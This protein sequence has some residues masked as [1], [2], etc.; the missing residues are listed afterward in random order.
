MAPEIKATVEEEEFDRRTVR[1][2]NQTYLQI[3]VVGRLGLENMKGETAVL[4]IAKELWGEA[5]E[6]GEGKATKQAAHLWGVN[7]LS[8]LSWKLTPG[9]RAI[10]M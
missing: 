10:E 2:A 1:L 3:T 7:P 5:I 6:S 4:E 8:R 9:R